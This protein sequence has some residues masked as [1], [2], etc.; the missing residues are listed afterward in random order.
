[1]RYNDIVMDHFDNPRNAGDL[2]G[3]DAVGKAENPVCMDR[4]T[5]AL[6]WDSAT[7]RVAEAR[8]RAEGCVPAMA[9]AS[10]LTEL[11]V[12]QDRAG[13][14]RINAE[15][16]ERALGGLPATKKH[17]AHLAADALANALSDPPAQ[18]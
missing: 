6:R 1:M 4:M 10:A 13:L 17:A 12:G 15:A 11:L 14:A 3:A 7:G 2:P 5:V 18:E 8:F 16:V 9:A